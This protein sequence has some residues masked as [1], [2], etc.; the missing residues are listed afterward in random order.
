MRIIKGIWNRIVFFSLKIRLKSCGSQTLFEPE[1]EVEGAKFITIGSKVRSKSRFHLAA[2]N[3]HNGVRF[4]PSIVIHDNVSINYD[5][6]IAAIN[7]V[8]IGKSSLIASKVFITDHFHGDTTYD[9]LNIPP[10][11]RTLFSKGPVIIG[12]NVWI[13][14]G[15]AIMPGVTIGNNSIIGANSVVTKSIPAFSVACGVP[16]R[17]IKNVEK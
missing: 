1:F 15:A 5:V 10:S 6:H 17:I 12:E 11:E 16:A 2:I 4:E 3:Y 9:S 7:K 14:E 13:G 8:I